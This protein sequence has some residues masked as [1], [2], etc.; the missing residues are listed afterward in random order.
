MAPY[1]DR[2]IDELPRPWVAEE[3]RRWQRERFAA[4]PPFETD[5]DRVAE[6]K[7]R[8]KR[9]ARVRRAVGGKKYLDA[10]GRVP[11][12]PSAAAITI[13]AHGRAEP[14][15]DELLER[16]DAELAAFDIR[17]AEMMARVG[18]STPRPRVPPREDDD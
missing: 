16:F 13:S 12:S 17:L 7:V 6:R 15:T 11:R 9:P 8:P 4:A 1:G 2:R 14:I 3:H 10:I 5:E 18:Q